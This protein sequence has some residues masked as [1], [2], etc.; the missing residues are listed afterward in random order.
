LTA[1]KKKQERKRN[2]KITI[3]D[4]L[5]RFFAISFPFFLALENPINHGFNYSFLKSFLFGCNFWADG[6]FN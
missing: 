6:I 2:E 1:H 4:P 3:S 5:T